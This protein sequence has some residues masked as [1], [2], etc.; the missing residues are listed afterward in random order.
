VHNAE[1]RR[2]IA[3]ERAVDALTRT[4]PRTSITSSDEARARARQAVATVFDEVGRHLLAQY[5]ITAGQNPR[6]AADLYH[7]APALAAP[8]V[9]IAGQLLDIA[10]RERTTTRRVA[11]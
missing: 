1:Q 10:H 7:R 5:A 8:E 9:Q 2:N 11:A 6:A 3:F 4:M